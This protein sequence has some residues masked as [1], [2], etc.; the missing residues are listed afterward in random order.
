MRLHLSSG[1]G[2]LALR[3]CEII[4]WDS[5]SFCCVVWLGGQADSLDE[6]DSRLFQTGTSSS[7]RRVLGHPHSDTDDGPST[8][9]VEE[10][11]S[12]EVQEDSM[13]LAGE[14]SYVPVG[15][16]AGALA[17]QA[18]SKI[19]INPP[20]P[21]RWVYIT[22]E[23]YLRDGRTKALTNTSDSQ[24]ASSANDTE[25]APTDAQQISSTSNDTAPTENL[26][27][28]QLSPSS[29]DSSTA[30]TQ[31]PTDNDTQ[32]GTEN[33]TSPPSTTNGT[34]NATPPP[35]QPPPT[36]GT[37][38]ATSPPSPSES[39]GTKPAIAPEA[40]QPAIAPIPSR[41]S[42]TPEPTSSTQEPD[43]NAE[44][45]G[46]EP[47]NN[48]GGSDR[49]SSKTPSKTPKPG[50]AAGREVGKKNG[51]IG[52]AIKGILAKPTRT[53]A[54]GLSAAGSNSKRVPPRKPYDKNAP[55]WYPVSPEMLLQ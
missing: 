48:P 28:D 32:N 9:G 38:N 5:A 52:S 54:P 3:L 20:P 24:Q 14:G 1:E 27:P 35:T 50:Q 6:T 30:G 18:A 25:S 17:G 37:D 45:G 51:T 47:S 41:P 2:R 53:R 15:E 4:R 21:G 29:N 10:F 7:S 49:G 34:E 22:D 40:Q 44:N 16:G 55:N 46:N 31:P 11:G 36:N 43:D 42:P 39:N 26:K 19:S 23:D 33:A 13:K 8:T 12:K